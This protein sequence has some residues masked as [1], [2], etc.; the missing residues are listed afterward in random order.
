[1]QPKPIPDSIFIGGRESS[2][3]ILSRYD[4]RWAQRYEYERSSIASAMGD[5]IKR[6]EHIGSTSVPGLA[7]K[8]IIDVLVAVDDV[9]DD[10]AY[11]SPLKTIGYVLRVREIGHRMFRSASRDVHVHL[12][13]VDSAEIERHLAFRNRL[14]QD[15][16]SRVL[17]ERVK[18]QL[19]A[20]RWED[21]ND[22]AQ[23]KSAV[24][25]EIVGYGG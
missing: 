4:P 12:W 14:R 11:G 24:I 3:I 18:R 15:K 8:P 19:A 23:A 10:A 5:R 21:T 17:Y 7:A 20:K 1:M 13:S 9:E 25:A 22:Y 16:A 2:R 6:I